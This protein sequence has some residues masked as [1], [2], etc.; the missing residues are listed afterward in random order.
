MDA[1]AARAPEELGRALRWAAQA[2]SAAG[3]EAA[4]VDAELLAAHLLSQSRGAPVSRGEMAALALGGSVPTP[5]GFEQAV[6]ER[7]R[8][9]PLQHLT[10]EAYFR[11]LVLSVGPGVFVPRP[12]T[13]VLVD[14]INAYLA[15]GQAPGEPHVVDLATG[16]GALALAVAQENPG[17]RVTGVELSASACSWARRNAE[18]L[19]RSCPQARVEILLEDATTALPGL[20]GT[21]DA[22]VTN[23][24]Y[25]P[26]SMVPVDPEVAEHDP[27]MALYGGSAD[28]LRIPRA[29]LDRA[30]QLLRP[31]GLLVME[32]A[33]V[34]AEAM[35]QSFRE[36]GLVE[37]R[38][39]ADLTGRDRATEGRRHYAGCGE[40][41]PGSRAREH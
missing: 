15:S 29:F 16:S 14:R 35:A 41:D 21:V 30:V 4:R 6:Q 13:E 18:S 23:P 7:A 22:V 10:G 3:I 34:Q 38:T 1:P 33:E 37:V 39:V 9:I 36:Q 19:R 5:E 8:R 12:E 40:T 25:I 20:E 27:A 24:P 32:H 31:G 28:G 17:T 2:L 11:H 26:E